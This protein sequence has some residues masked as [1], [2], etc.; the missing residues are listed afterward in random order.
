MPILITITTISYLFLRGSGGGSASFLD[1]A[2]LRKKLEEL[3]VE[4]ARAQALGIADQLDT[5]ARDYDQATEAAMNAYLTDVAKWRSSASSL[6]DVLQQ[7]DQVRGSVLR[8]LVQL[9]R[10]LRETLSPA[11]WDQVFAA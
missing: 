6:I 3:P 11:E 7:Q 9:R 10:S 2:A 1:P 4:S 8:D 5:L